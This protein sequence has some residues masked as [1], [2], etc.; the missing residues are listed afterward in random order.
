MSVRLLGRVTIPPAHHQP[1]DG[2]A[3]V[4]SSPCSLNPRL[5]HHRLLV[6]CGSAWPLRRYP[7]HRDGVGHWARFAGRAKAFLRIEFGHPWIEAAG[8]GAERREEGRVL[9]PP[10]TSNRTARPVGSRVEED[11][12]RPPPGGGCHLPLRV[13]SCGLCPTDWSTGAG[14]VGCFLFSTLRGEYLSEALGAKGRGVRPGPLIPFGGIGLG[15]VVTCSK[16]PLRLAAARH[17]P[18]RVR[19]R[20]RRVSMLSMDVSAL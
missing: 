11:P 5:P 4:C 7:V 13:I 8:R 18:L 15:V 10:G 6:S 20:P 3:L 16:H 19:S 2:D 9:P 1:V 12:F 17:L 14:W